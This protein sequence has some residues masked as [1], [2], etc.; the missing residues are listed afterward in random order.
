MSNRVTRVNENIFITSI[1]KRIKVAKLIKN[2]LL[3]IDNDNYHRASKSL[4]LD[5]EILYDET[6]GYHIIQLKFHGRALMTTRKFF[7]NYGKKHNLLNG[8]DMLFL[9]TQDFELA[10]ALR[11][12]N[13]ISKLV[14]G[15]KDFDIFTV[16]EE[17]RKRGLSETNKLFRAWEQLQTEN[18]NGSKTVSRKGSAP[19]GNTSN[20]SRRSIKM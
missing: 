13:K 10:K 7:I 6:L 18:S 16:F 8:R 9:P 20:G 17:Q 5:R 1:F 19:Q 14:T 12:E 11:W 3:V 15:L 4:G 2:S